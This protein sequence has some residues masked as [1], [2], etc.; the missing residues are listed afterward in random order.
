MVERW[1]ASFVLMV[2]CHRLHGV[3]TAS[4]LLA[5]TFWDTWCGRGWLPVDVRTMVSKAVAFHHFYS[6]HVPVKKDVVQGAA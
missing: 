3:S 6:M 4:T 2:L 1:S 5:V